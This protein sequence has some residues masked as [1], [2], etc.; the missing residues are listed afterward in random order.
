MMVEWH[1]VLSPPSDSM[2]LF[3]PP[4]S[5]LRECVILLSDRT[6]PTLGAQHL[7]AMNVCASCIIVSIKVLLLYST[8]S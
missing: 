3:P 8:V 4:P 5:L 6:A 2:M 7:V 1:C